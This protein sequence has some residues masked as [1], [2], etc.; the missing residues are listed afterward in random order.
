MLY[1]ITPLYS[2]PVYAN[3][4]STILW[5]QAIPLNLAN[6]QAAGPFVSASACTALSESDY[7]ADTANP[8]PSS[9][10]DLSLGSGTQAIRARFL[11]EHYFDAQAA[12]TFDLSESTDSL[13]FSGAKTG[14][15]KAPTT[16][17][18]GLLQTGA[19]DWL[20]LGDNTRGLSSGVTAVYRVV[21]AGG[22]AQACSVSGSSAPGQAFSVPYVAEYWF[23][24]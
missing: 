1:D 5:E 11:G 6:P 15:V 21:T 8:F 12:P 19:V 16:A 10:E 14:N 3:I 20:E 13:F 2:S 7:Q 17:D 4:T 22:V 18:K 9:P 23:Y 24:G